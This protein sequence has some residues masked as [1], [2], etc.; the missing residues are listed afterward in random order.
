MR[1]RTVNDADQRVGDWLCASGRFGRWLL[2]EPRGVG[3]HNDGY[4]RE[5]SDQDTAYDE[6]DHHP[7]SLQAQ[8]QS[9]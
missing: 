5:Q 7:K 8:A 1:A 6:G 4:Q 3:H 2:P 9:M